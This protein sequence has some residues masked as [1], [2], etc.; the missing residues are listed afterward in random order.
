[1][2]KVPDV[3][4]RS[5]ERL[6][7][8]REDLLKLKKPKYDLIL[9]FINDFMNIKF[10]SLLHF[11]NINLD[12]NNHKFE[13]SL[14]NYRDKLEGNLQI[15]LS[16]NNNISNVLSICL[17]TIDYSIHSHKITNSKTQGT[18]TLSRIYDEIKKDYTGNIT[19]S[20]FLKDLQKE[21]NKKKSD[22]KKEKKKLVLSFV[23]DA[24]NLNLSS[25][26]KFKN[27]DCESIDEDNFENVVNKYKNELEEKLGIEIENTIDVCGILGDC[28]KCVGFF[29]KKEKIKNKNKDMQII[30]SAIEKSK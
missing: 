5:Y 8:L 15:D 3:K 6:H 25:L 7:D 30:M 9:E 26:S 28:I 2:S 11:K 23:C 16:D 27:I 18:R 1:M 12:R 24:T 17:E 4:K 21:A 14:E 20:K 19:A 22:E 29:F 10:E 13:I